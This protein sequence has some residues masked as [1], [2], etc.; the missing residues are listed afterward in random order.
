MDIG[1]WQVGVTQSDMTEQLAHIHFSYSFILV[2][3]W[4]LLHTLFYFLKNIGRHGFMV[5]PLFWDPWQVPRV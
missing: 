5:Q 4:G 3:L 2:V 1:T